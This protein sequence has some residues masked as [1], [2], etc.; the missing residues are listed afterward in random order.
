MALGAVLAAALTDHS[1]RAFGLYVSGVDMIRQPGVQGNGYGVPIGTVTVDER[2]PGQVSSMSFVISD[3]LNVTSVLEGADVRFVNLTKDVIEFAGWVDTASIAPVATGRQITVQCV[4]IE[5]V[6]DWMLVPSLTIPALTLLPD[7][8]QMIASAAVAIG[9]PLQWAQGSSYDATIQV[10][11]GIPILRALTIT[12][13]TLRQALDSLSAA[14]LDNYPGGFSIFS[15]VTFYG[16]L[17]YDG[18]T[19][20]IA[21]YPFSP[22]TQRT[23]STAGPVYPA[24]PTH[25]PL[26]GDSVRNVYVV[27]GNAAGTGLFTDGSGVPGRT[28]LVSDSAIL[29]ASAAASAASAAMGESGAGVTGSFNLE[30]FSQVAGR[31]NALR[32]TTQYILTNPQL[33]LSSTTVRAQVISKTFNDSGTEEWTVAYGNRPRSGA[34]LIRALTSTRLN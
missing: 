18:P 28:A 17:W 20:G 31:D 30:A 29:T 13:Q 22:L 27:G 19:S 10:S 5:S 1:S 4:G 6:L 21:P 32:V 34:A 14:A 25:S 12:N 9:V 33:G 24:N 7:A 15:T 16:G 11:S 23:V 2:A 26:Q 3:P 8:A